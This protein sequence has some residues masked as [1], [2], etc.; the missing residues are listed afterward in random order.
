M[1]RTEFD[2][3]AALHRQLY[4]SL[5]EQIRLQYAGKYVALAG[6]QL[7]AVTD[8]FD[9]AQVAIQQLEPVPDYYLIFPAE[10][11]PSFELAYDF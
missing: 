1:N 11:E 9:R 5:R 4:D 7:V 2:R 8:S 6:G 3:E 10:A